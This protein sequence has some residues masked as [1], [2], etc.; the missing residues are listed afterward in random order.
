VNIIFVKHGELYSSDHVNL[1]YN[2]L[3]IYYPHAIFWCYTEN[4][5]NICSEVNIIPVLI[6][7]TLKKWWNKLALFSNDM[8]FEGECL[9]F[10]LDMEIISD[11]SSFITD[12]TKLTIINAY[13]KNE[14]CF[15]HHAYNVK[16]NSSI[17]AWTHGGQQHI[18][19]KFLINKDYYMRKYAGIDR[20]LVHENIMINTFKD[21]IVNSIA[22]KLYENAPVN[23]YNGISYSL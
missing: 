4:P 22:N 15:E 1:L 18:W 8:P 3:S 10:D 9:F 12:Y 11:P 20:F 17:I 2:K 7:P 5:Y 13:Y 14:L 16:I 6:K 19:D 21:G 23:M